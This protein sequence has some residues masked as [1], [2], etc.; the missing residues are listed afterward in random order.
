MSKNMIIT[1]DGPAGSGKSTS[2]KLVAKKLGYT[3]L[4][5][6]AM[7]RAITYLA[8]KQNMI[9]DESSVVR[10]AQ[11][12]RLELKFIDG[13]TEVFLNGEDV[14]EAIRSYEVNS[15]V[16]EISVIPGV[17]KAL[18]EKQQAI[19]ANTSIV[20]EG[21][22]TGTVVFPDAD[23]KIF[24]TASLNERATRRLKE[25]QEKGQNLP[26]EDIEFNIKKRDLIDSSREMSPL[27]KAK[28][29]IEIDTSSITIEEEVSLILAKVEEI[30][31]E[32]QK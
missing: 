29:A 2:A 3:Y 9:R 30:I 4:D 26:L 16:S 22:D 23:V 8:L 7:Y 24:L 1:I 32:K 6:G 14:T 28:D 21:R 17:R 25:F 27:V 13:K 5:T 15:N 11:D 31:K 19:G 10:L 20:A 18:V 12:A